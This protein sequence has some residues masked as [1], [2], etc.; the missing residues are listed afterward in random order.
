VCGKAELAVGWPS[1]RPT[2]NRQAS[3]GFI[4]TAV[5]SFPHLPTEGLSHVDIVRFAGAYNSM[6]G[7]GQRL[8]SCLHS[9][10]HSACVPR[11]RKL[12]AA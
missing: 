10:S 7:R 11:P 6:G 3:P 12:R 8:V 1:G 9:L 2:P 5:H 4:N